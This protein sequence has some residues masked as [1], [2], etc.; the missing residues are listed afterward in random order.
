M[1][2]YI[3]RE[4]VIEDKITRLEDLRFSRQIQLYA[5]QSLSPK[6]VKKLT[7]LTLKQ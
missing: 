3:K 6:P 7:S 5:I 1:K 2:V 4:R